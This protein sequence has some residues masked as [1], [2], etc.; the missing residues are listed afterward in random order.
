MYRK[1]E[2]TF[3]ARSVKGYLGD[4]K[5]EPRLV[6]PEEIWQQ[7][8][9]RVRNTSPSKK[10]RSG[11]ARKRTHSAS[12]EGDEEEDQ[13]RRDRSQQEQYIQVD[14]AIDLSSDKSPDRERLGTR[15]KDEQRRTLVHVDSTEPPCKTTRIR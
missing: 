7:K 15:A 10:S 1:Y 9:E 4:S 5:M 11:S 3:L 6:A 8:Q 14:S 2:S 12:Q 13:E